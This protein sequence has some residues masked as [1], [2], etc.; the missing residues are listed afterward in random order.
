MTARLSSSVRTRKMN[1]RSAIMAILVVAAV[2][3]SQTKPADSTPALLGKPEAETLAEQ[4]ITQHKLN[5]G[6][7]IK[8]EEHGSFGYWVWYETPEGEKTRL[9]PRVITINRKDGSTVK[10]ERR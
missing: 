7:P 5:W 3:C 6:A 9:G 2:G 4:Y 8:I 10:I 1:I